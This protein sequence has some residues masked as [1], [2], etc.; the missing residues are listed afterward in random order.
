MSRTPEHP[1]VTLLRDGYAAFAMGDLDRIRAVLAEDVV[2]SVSGRNKI[3][4]DYRGRDEVLEF[5]VRLF[6]LSGG[7]FRSEPYVF[8]ADD[9]HGVVLIRATAEHAGG[10]LDDHGVD[11][12]RFAGDQIIEIRSL[13]GDQNAVD[14]F[15]S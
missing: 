7:T 3:S 1:H 10:R 14:E 15:W 12:H 4:G 13:A 5:Y 11:I 9:G 2:H 8:L 6:D